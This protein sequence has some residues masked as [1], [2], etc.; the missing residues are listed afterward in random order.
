M[1]AETSPVWPFVRGGNP[2]HRLAE[3]AVAA[4]GRVRVGGAEV[5]VVETKPRRA[6]VVGDRG[7]GLDLIRLV[8]ASRGK[9]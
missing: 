6:H 3:M 1:N 9:L 5:D 7:R 8:S 2:D 4:L